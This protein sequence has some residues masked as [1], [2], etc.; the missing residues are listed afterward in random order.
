MTTTP[1]R[2]TPRSGCPGSPAATTWTSSGSSLAYYQSGSLVLD[3]VDLQRELAAGRQAIV[4]N[5]VL[6]ELGHVIGLAHVDVPG[7]IMAGSG[8]TAQTQFGP[9]DLRGL[10]ALSSRQCL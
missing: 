5:I 1:R 6:H 10:R 3:R 9:G 8:A 2:T 7:E 4:E